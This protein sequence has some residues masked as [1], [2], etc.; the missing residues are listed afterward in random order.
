[1]NDI[2]IQARDLTKVYRLYAGP[3]YRF[4]DMFGLLKNKVG[5]YTEHAALDGVSLEIRSGEKVAFIG[6]NGAG[7]STLLKLF[8]GVIEP[9]SGTLAVKGKAHALL[10]IG[11]GFHPDFTG[12]E[13]VYA[14]L[15]Q[16]GI[17]GREADRKFTEIVEFAELEEYVG[18]P[19]KTYSSG[20]AVRLMFATSTAITPDLLVL[21]EVLG[22][23]DAYF[24]QKS[25]RRI[26]E[27]CQR[28]GTTLLLVTHDVYSATAICD[29][30]VW[31]DRGRILMDA[32]G[33]TVINAYEHSIRLQ[34]E[35]RLRL[36]AQARARDWASDGEA[37]SVTVELHATDATPQPCPVYFSR[38]ELFAGD[39]SLGILPLDEAPV[40]NI[41]RQSEGTSW[42]E[43]IEWEG[44]P[45]RPLLNFGSPFHKVAG[46]F[47]SVPGD[48]APGDLRAEVDYWFAEPCAVAV[49]AFV[50]GHEVAL[51]SLQPSAGSWRTHRSSEANAAVPTTAPPL[52][53]TGRQGT[54]AI[55]V[56]VVTPLDENDNEAYAFKHGAP[57]KLRLRYRINQPDL[58]ERAQVLVAFV[59]DGVQDV[60]RTIYRD[61]T[62]DA[63]EQLEGL[64]ELVFPRLP[65]A[66]GTYALTIM[67]VRE[68][69]FDEPQTL[70]FSINPGVYTCL[71]RAF[72]IKV[73]DGGIVGTG[74][75]VVSEGEWR[76]S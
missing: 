22:V 29:R 5:A 47:A 37:S 40:P 32:D 36:K 64:V 8:T 52:T 43:A 6:R 65:L 9:S 51:G 21:D 4:L 76:K 3:G 50:D 18:Q 42:G 14:Y 60:M 58:H 30:V 63:S 66:T 54:G 27:L 49:R 46:V 1:M 70:Y 45:S 17:T 69:Y 67:V 39:V 74:T 31:I 25:Y 12:R 61:F 35:S 62:F 2:V 59:R 26:R 55:V 16:L 20:M 23:G 53:P 68:N 19:V 11:S 57:F 13:N 56:E 7:K 44:R 41:T 15:A 72:D 75:G 38:I 24:A 33:A 73:E 28:D 48:L 10:Q 71:T 34:E